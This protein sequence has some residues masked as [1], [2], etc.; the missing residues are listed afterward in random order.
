MLADSR[1]T[2]SNIIWAVLTFAILGG[3]IFWGAHW[4]ETAWDFTEFY[5]AAHVPVGS[6]HDQAVF[7]ETAHRLLAGK[8]ITYVPPYVRPA[9]FT[10][11]LRWMRGLP[12][13]DAYRIWA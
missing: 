4:G 6:L 10:L 13:W 8:G 9:V 12:Y 5:V 3:W 1:Q 2:R 7:Q 11:A